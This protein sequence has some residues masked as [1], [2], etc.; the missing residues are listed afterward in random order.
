MAAKKPENM[1]FEAAIGE[2]KSIVEAMEQGDLS[3][4]DSLKHFE[5]GI[6]LARSSQQKLENAEQRVQ[7]LV[8]DSSLDPNVAADDSATLDADFVPF[9]PHQDS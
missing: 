9:T 5:R 8:Q 1:P 3:L 7:M 6:Q 2:L 4:D